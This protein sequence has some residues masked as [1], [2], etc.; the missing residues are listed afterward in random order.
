MSARP[1]RAT[2]KAQATQPQQTHLA[3]RQLSRHQ[4]EVRRQRIAIIAVAAALVVALL[5]PVYGFWHQTVG[6]GGD[7][8]AVVKGQTITTETYARFLGYENLLLE[9]EAKRLSDALAQAT[10]EATKTTLQNQL[11]LIQQRASS[12]PDD[13]LSYLVDR[14]FVLQEAATRG[15]T[16]SPEELDVALQREM[17]SYPE[18]GLLYQ[19]A[20]EVT[21][22]KLVTVDQARA[23]LTSLVNSAPFLTADEVRDI[24]LTQ[25]V[26]RSKIIGSL[27]AGIPT[28]AEQVHARHI[29]VATEA[30]AKAARD[31]IVNGEDFAAVAK[32]VSTDT[33]SKDKGGDLGWFPRD[34]MV[35]EF[36][37]AA[38]SLAV[39]DLS[40]PVKTSYGYHII[41]VIEKA[42]D[43]PLDQSFLNQ[44][45]ASAFSTLVSGLESADGAA[46]TLNSTDKTTWAE[47]YVT[48]RL[49][50]AK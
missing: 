32:A 47:K 12:L 50:A 38:F 9:R 28:T 10:D 22:D 15:L 2:R 44:Q 27:A 18:G 40:Q 34:Q 25:R 5:I 26:L 16:A 19:W 17:T 45:Y 33:S 46:Q 14:Q 43:R 20:N 6:I 37:D 31:R 23:A 29:L 36:A 13:V 24:S 35:K 7:A 30:E 48:D 4:R 1:P 49:P 42:A 39:G 3:R 11:S 21:P 8:I 41:Q